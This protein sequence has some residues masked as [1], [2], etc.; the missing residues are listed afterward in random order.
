MANKRAEILV[1]ISCFQTLILS[2]AMTNH[3]RHILQMTLTAFFTNGTIMRVVQ[4]QIFNHRFAKTLRVICVDRESC[5]FRYGRHTRHHYSATR[6][7]LV[8]VTHDS[9]LSTCTN[10]AHGR[11]PAEIGYVN[12]F[13][14]QDFQKVCAI[15][16]FDSLPVDND[17]RHQLTP[18]LADWF[19]E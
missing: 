3:Y 16:S 10:T 18:R 19:V 1:A 9:T 2:I 8:G 17:V 5:T 15:F 11:M 12:T 6:I 14:Q 4:H 7:I 13:V